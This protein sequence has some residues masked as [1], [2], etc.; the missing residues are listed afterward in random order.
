M[1]NP[2]AEPALSPGDSRS[3]TRRGYT[4]RLCRQGAHLFD[5]YSGLNV[6]LDEVHVPLDQLSRAP[7]YVSI[8]LTNACDLRCAYCYAPKHAAKLDADQVIGWA[9]ELDSAGCLGIGFGGGEPTTHPRFAE[10]C[11]RIAQATSLAVTFT[12]HGHRLTPVLADLLR[13]SVHFA[14]LSVDGVGTTYERLRGRPFS[15][16]ITAA[17]L[18][19][20]V[21]PIGVNTVVNAE[22][23][24]E[25]DEI[26]SFA[27]SIGA[28]ELL[29]LPQQPTAAAGGIAPSDVE[30]LV[31]WVRDARPDVR[32]A[33]ARS[34]FESS[35]PTVELIPG[36]HPLDAHMHLDAT[37]MLRPDAFAAA[38][39]RVEA[40][41][42]D[43]VEALKE[44]A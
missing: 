1:Q 30:R 9:I 35:L 19:S 7:R 29:L 5:R 39:T 10:L 12:T 4:V 44:A 14:R 33:I 37:G 23:V 38:G 32:L 8:A 41:V 43:A 22:T 31:D 36:E 26:A 27:A 3:L 28:I 34:G 21:A 17:T 13:G 40:S 16:V 18:L 20:S 42:L 24:V 11:Q 2:R 6:L 15:R 25:L